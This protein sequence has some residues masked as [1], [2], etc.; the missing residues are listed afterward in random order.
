MLL[1]CDL[2]TSF[3]D[4]EPKYKLIEE[5]TFTDLNKVEAAL[6]GTYTP[7]RQVWYIPANIMALSGN[8]ESFISP[9]GGPFYANEVQYDNIYVQNAYSLYY[10]IIQRSSYI[11]DAMQNNPDIK[12]LS[13]SRRSEV[14]GEAR[15]QRAMA[16]FHLLELF[17]QFYDLDSELG[18]V[19]KM[20]PSRVN[21]PLKRN[22]VKEVYTAILEDLDFSIDNAPAVNVHYRMSQTVAKAYK[23]KVLLY[24]KDYTNAAA[25]ALDVMGDPNYELEEDYASI[26]SNGYNSKEVL[27]S[28]FAKYLQEQG[29]VVSIPLSSP[30]N[31]A[32]IADAEVIGVEGDPNTG[33]GFD[34]RYAFAH[35]RNTLPPSAR[36]AKYPFAFIPDQQDNSH[37]VMR[38]AEVYLIYA[39]AKARL[40]SGVDAD[41]LT[42]MND[43]RTR[44]DMPHKSPATKADLLEAIRIEKNLELFGEWAQPWFDLVRYHKLGDLN[45]SDIKSTITSDDQLILPMPLQALAGN[46]DLEQNPGYSGI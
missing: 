25:L 28:P 34:K 32:S 31:I 41:A 43:I 29:F 23:A 14:E 10:L 5:S 39:E 9:I 6:N 44:A 40:S 36:N 33:E 35:A 8:Y 19:V 7:W 18:I 24:Q 4:I 11:I 26:F 37:F 45:I 12:E 3:D 1:S 27:F 20:E 2:I 46:S 22:T 15:I 30:R 13:A 38:L 42:A 16:H 17:G 21:E